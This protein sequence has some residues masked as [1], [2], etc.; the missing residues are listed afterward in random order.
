MF[1]KRINTQSDSINHELLN[2]D[3]QKFFIE[4]FLN[5]VPYIGAILDDS[6][7]V[8]LHN[9]NFTMVLARTSTD[10]IIGKRPGDIFGCVNALR[11]SDGCGSTPACQYCG[12]LRTVDNSRKTGCRTEDTVHILAS[13]N[14][15][16]AALDLKIIATPF[17]WGTY[18][19]TI[20]TF[21][22]LSAE[23]RRQMLE[24][25]FFHDIINSVGAL[26][27]LSEI[28]ESDPE[29]INRENLNIL[30]ESAKKI[31]DEVQSQKILLYA[32]THELAVVKVSIDIAG[33][34]KKIIEQMIFTA[35]SQ[36]KDII[37]NKSES[38][39]CTTDI[40]LLQRVL[41]NLL[42]NAIDA[43]QPGSV[44]TCDYYSDND[45]ATISINNPG[46]IPDEVKYH[47][48]QRSFS[49]KGAGRGVGTYS[50]KLLTEQY[51]GGIAFFSSEPETGTT[52]YVRIPSGKPP[53]D[54]SS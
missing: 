48:F 24:R 33:I 7:R 40:V 49:T 20:V 27:G 44:I 19:Y 2:L 3:S 28:F 46:V 43:I 12:I 54:I 9:K 16:T 32:E 11:G 42:K 50:V 47:I 38:V 18:S 25:I 6:N 17:T 41:L 31:Y 8:L 15:Q 29:S 10:S 1:E 37:L 23:H 26:M 45:Y 21:E 51:L 36:Q 35:K 13:N 53:F 34:L 14:N 4:T 39:Y 52:F 5:T 22:D 30:S